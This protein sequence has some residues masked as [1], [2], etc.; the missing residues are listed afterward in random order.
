MRATDDVTTLGE[1]LFS[2]APRRLLYLRCECGFC[3]ANCA[4]QHRRT[5]VAAL[6]F[7][8]FF[9]SQ[10]GS[11]LFC[12]FS[13]AVVEAPPLA[14]PLRRAVRSRAASVWW[15][16]GTGERVLAPA[17]ASSAA[18]TSRHNRRHSGEPMAMA[19]TII[20]PSLPSSTYTSIICLY[21]HTHSPSVGGFQ[22]N[23]Y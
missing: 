2:I 1:Q 6:S 18:R 11:L 3:A 8:F 23:P 22:L 17:A 20:P 12:L 4:P 10:F 21:P 13:C 5:F 15:P 9:S 16:R 14:T 19:A 7:S